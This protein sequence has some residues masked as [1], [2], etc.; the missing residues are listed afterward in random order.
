M[1]GQ[2]KNSISGALT[3]ECV[4]KKCNFKKRL[5]ARY[6]WRRVP[7][8]KLCDRNYNIP[9]SMYGIREQR[10]HPYNT[11][12]LYLRTSHIFQYVTVQY[13]DRYMGHTF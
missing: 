4:I 11:A 9:P 3:S 2:N 10:T 13:K 8:V 5:P 12:L 6:L 7:S 1:N